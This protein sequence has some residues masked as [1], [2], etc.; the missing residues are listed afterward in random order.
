[1]T[2]YCVQIDEN[3]TV[4]R[5]LV[6]DSTDWCKKSFGGNWI[7]VEETQEINNPIPS[8]DGNWEYLQESYSFRLKQ[9][10][11]SWIWNNENWFWDPPIPYPEDGKCYLWNEKFLEWVEF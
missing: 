3:N 1:M 2:K 10:Y 11:E 5:V 8:E 6:A 4:T 7:L 9:P